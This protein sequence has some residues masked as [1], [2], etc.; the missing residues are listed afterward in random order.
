[1]EVDEVKPKAM[2]ASPGAVEAHPGDVET[3]TGA[4]SII[5]HPLPHQ[6]ICSPA[7]FFEQYCTSVTQD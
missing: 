5:P 3:H 4:K 6:L 7:L 2:E 1:M